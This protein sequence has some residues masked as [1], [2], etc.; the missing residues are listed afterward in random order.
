MAALRE[1]SLPLEGEDEAGRAGIL[2]PGRTAPG[3]CPSVSFSRCGPGRQTRRAGSREARG[4]DPGQPGGGWQ[5]PRDC[6][7]WVLLKSG[8]AKVVR[9]IVMKTLPHTSPSTR[10]VTHHLLAQSRG[11][12]PSA[13][14]RSPWASSPL[15]TSP[16]V[17]SGVWTF[18][19]RW[20][21]WGT[22]P[23]G[24][25]PC[26]PGSHGKLGFK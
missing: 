15:Q 23:L 17:G 3:P 13:P 16:R 6:L 10:E 11:P 20:G 21:E 22:R 25:G 14:Q 24:E 7:A 9:V 4:R 2:T 26:L 5:P 18:T 19:S 12:D 8:H 1:Q